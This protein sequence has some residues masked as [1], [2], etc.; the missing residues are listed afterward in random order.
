[1]RTAAATA[2]NTSESSRLVRRILP[3]FGLVA[4]LAYICAVTLGGV[5]SPGYSQVSQPISD[6]IAQS[7]PHKALLDR[8]FLVYNLST[9]SFGALLIGS[10]RRWIPDTGRPW[11]TI[12][13][14]TLVLEGLCGLLTQLFP[15]ARG[16]IQS[17]I[18]FTGRLHMAFAGLSSLST[19]LAIA[20]LGIWCRRIP[21]LR[22]RAGWC[23]AAVG[24]IFLTGAV[25]AV[26]M[27]SDSSYTGLFERLTIG[28]FLVWLGAFALAMRSAMG[29]EPR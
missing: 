18:T 27:A 21:R 14:A 24:F 1:M 16:G 15:E 11:G 12:G 5:L 17:E 26:A 10:A 6:L 28:G 7:A 29:P 3:I 20:F 25:T 9:L 19:M 4:P 13:A 22:K 8:L 2:Q 23:F